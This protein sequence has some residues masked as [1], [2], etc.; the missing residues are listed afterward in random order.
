VDTADVLEL[1]LASTPAERRALGA[2]LARVA[3]DDAAR[4]GWRVSADAVT[5]PR[6]AQNYG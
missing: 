1:E 5:C 2:V 4:A 3:T 6:C